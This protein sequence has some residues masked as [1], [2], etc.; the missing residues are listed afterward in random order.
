[1]S[2]PHR[3]VGQSDPRTLL[4]PASQPLLAGS[5]LRSFKWPFTFVQPEAALPSSAPTLRLAGVG[6]LSP[7]LRTA[8]YSFARPGRDTWTSQ[9]SSGLTPFDTSR[10]T[11]IWSHRLKARVFRS[12]SVTIRSYPTPGFRSDDVREAALDAAEVEAADQQQGQADGA[13]DGQGVASRAG[14]PASAGGSWRSGRRP[15]SAA[16]VIASAGRSRRRPACRCSGVANIQ[17]W[18]RNGTT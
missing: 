5:P 6:A 3:R 17:S 1:M 4:V 13:G 14:R 7:G 8:D 16:A 15:G 11:L 10:S 9:G 2:P 18:T 12:Q